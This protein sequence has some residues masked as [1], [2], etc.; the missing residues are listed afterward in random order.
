MKRVIFLS[1]SKLAA[2]LLQ[3]L[4]LD[5]N[6]DC[7]CLQDQNELK[8]K[9]FLQKKTLIIIDDSFATKTNAE[10]IT[11]FTNLTAQNTHKIFFLTDAKTPKKPPC[12]VTKILH[13]PFLADELIQNIQK[14][15]G[16]K[17]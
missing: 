5:T 7:L 14:Q 8:T 4:L 1:K 17:A 10:E 13:K 9:L 15:L 6:T 12:P 2:N 16:G 11:I 3:F